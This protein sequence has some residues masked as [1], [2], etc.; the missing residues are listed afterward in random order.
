MDSTTCHV[1]YVNRSVARDR[2]VYAHPQLRPQSQ[3]PSQPQ[4]PS[5]DHAQE[6]A[7]ASKISSNPSSSAPRD[8]QVADDGR[9]WHGDNV[10]QD[11][12]PLLDAFGDGKSLCPDLS[13]P[14]P[15]S[16]S[17]LLFAFGQFA[18]ATRLCPI[19]PC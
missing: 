10:R 5:Q 14:W 4:P 15:C 16:A 12:Q 6:H 17:K 8:K 11:I 18:F 2:L 1:I 19:I 7:E 9:D 13:S 3:P